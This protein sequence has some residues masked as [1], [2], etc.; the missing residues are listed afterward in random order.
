MLLSHINLC[1]YSESARSLRVDITCKSQSFAGVKVIRAW[2]RVKNDC[3]LVR[4]VSRPHVFDLCGHDFVTVV[5]TGKVDKRQIE[6][7]VSENREVDGHVDYAGFVL[8]S[9]F[10]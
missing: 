8:L 6:L 4:D 2:H 7:T 3:V 10:C 9:Q 5:Q 1:D